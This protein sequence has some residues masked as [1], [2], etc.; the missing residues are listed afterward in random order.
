MGAAAPLAEAASRPLPSSPSPAG[1]AGPDSRPRSWGGRP[2]MET[3]KPVPAAPA[4]VVEPEQAPLPLPPLTPPCCRPL[5]AVAARAPA[6]RSPWGE[7]L[8]SLSS[9]PAP[10][11]LVLPLAAFPHMRRERPAGSRSR[12]TG[13]GGGFFWREETRKLGCCCA[14]ERNYTTRGPP[15]TGE[16]FIPASAVDTATAA[17]EDLGYVGGGGGLCED[18]GGLRKQV[19]APASP[20]FPRSL[21]PS[22]PAACLRES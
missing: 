22:P 3:G 21:L 16:N 1:T 17:R 15:P 19:A 10:P 2:A 5:P 20:S 6:L 12:F 13:G 14:Y 4:V 18:R 11:P 9:P 7:W 8:G